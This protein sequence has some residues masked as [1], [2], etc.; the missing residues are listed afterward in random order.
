MKTGDGGAPSRVLVD[1]GTH[2]PILAG[3]TLFCNSRHPHVIPSAA[4]RSRGISL[5]SPAPSHYS[6]VEPALVKTG[7]GNPSPPSI[8]RS[9][10]FFESNPTP[11]K[12]N[13]RHEFDL[14]VESFP[15]LNKVKPIE[16]I[17]Q[18][19][20][21]IPKSNPLLHWPQTRLSVII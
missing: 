14:Q 7:A 5:P 13:L 1:A 8:I 11:K 17:P 2:P 18:Y 3:L 6:R 12:I 20:H 10:Y 21:S 16:E 4:K 19:P 15:R 9:H